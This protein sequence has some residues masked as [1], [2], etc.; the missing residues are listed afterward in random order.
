MIKSKL[1]PTTW[2]K[3]RIINDYK[4]INR[5]WVKRTNIRTYVVCTSESLTLKGMLEI[6]G[7][8]H[9]S[10]LKELHAALNQ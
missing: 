3:R 10:T 2:G 4:G 8:Y 5:L 6:N 7:D 9:F 1:I